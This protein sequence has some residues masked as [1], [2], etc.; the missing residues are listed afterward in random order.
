MGPIEVANG[1]VDMRD[2]GVEWRRMA[3]S[4]GQL[5]ICLPLPPIGHSHSPLFKLAV[6]TE[7]DTMVYSAEH[8][9][10]RLYTTSATK[11][12]DKKDC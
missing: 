1:G 4:I 10:W 6:P 12:P 8:R 5:L 9:I 11:H 7:T 3:S 2:W